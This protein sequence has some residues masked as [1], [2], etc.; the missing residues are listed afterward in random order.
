MDFFNRDVKSF[1]EMLETVEVEDCPCTIYFD[2]DELVCS[3]DMEWGSVEDKAMRKEVCLWPILHLDIREMM[4]K[5]TYRGVVVGCLAE[6][7]SKTRA[8]VEQTRGVKVLDLKKVI[9]IVSKRALDVTTFLQKGLSEKVYSSTDVIF[10]NHVRRLLDLKTLVRS[11]E[12][13][14]AV[15]VSAV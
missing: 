5:S 9:K 1:S 3:E 14:G 7:G 8:G 13:Y 2:Y 10:I 6:E 15:S 4:S 12:R 11:V